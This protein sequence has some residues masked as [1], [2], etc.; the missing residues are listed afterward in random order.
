MLQNRTAIAAPIGRTGVA[1]VLTYEAKDIDSH[2]LH[3]GPFAMG[4]LCTRASVSSLR[5]TGE[6][7]FVLGVL[8]N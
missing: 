6:L 7:I 5:H 2:S 1:P 3:G 8:T 4:L